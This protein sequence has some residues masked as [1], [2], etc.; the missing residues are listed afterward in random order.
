[1]WIAGKEISLENRHTRLSEKYK[2]RPRS[3]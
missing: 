3:P 2:N 1:M